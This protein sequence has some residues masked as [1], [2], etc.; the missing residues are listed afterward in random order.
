MH[1]ITVYIMGV[2]LVGMYLIGV[3]AEVESGQVVKFGAVGAALVL[4][5]WVIDDMVKSDEV[6]MV[7]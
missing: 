3:K 2:H 1:I 6:S 4:T 7:R 5:T